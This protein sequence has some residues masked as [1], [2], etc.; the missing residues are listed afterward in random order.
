[1][2]N[3]VIAVALLLALV[4][5]CFRIVYYSLHGFAYDFAI[6]ATAALALRRGLPLYD[7]L[8]MRQLGG[9]YAGPKLQGLF[10]QPF[11][12]Y[13]GPPTTAL[14]LV[15][16]TLLTYPTAIAVYR[17]CCLIVFVAALW[18]A[19]RSVPRE[20]RTRGM[21][22]ALF[23]L[24]LW[25]G[26]YISI[27][28]G[29]VDAFI[30]LSFALSMVVAGRERPWFVGISTGI[31]ALLK[32]SP[33]ILIPVFVLRRFYREVVV[34]LLTIGVLLALAT[35]VAGTHQMYIFVADI[36]PAL[37]QG[38]LHVENQSLPA[39][40]ARLIT[41]E[42]NFTDYTKGLGGFRFLS[43]PIALGGIWLAWLVARRRAD[44]PLFVSILLLA[45]LLAGPLTWGHYASWACI[46]IIPMLDQ[47]LWER[48]SPRERR[49]L[50]TALLVGF[51]LIGVPI[52]A[53]NPPR[54]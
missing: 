49:Y 54:K 35:W 12:S 46:A 40:I 17:L 48:R 9:E 53:I 41:P 4:W 8:L 51:L 27:T 20:S 25:D 30:A 28:I 32:V 38:S 11:N 36:A 15:P 7:P 22:W 5:F 42:T 13:I 10:T 14:L 26:V 1:M 50:G 23:A 37:S 45:A 47:G 6:N 21:L 52:Y 34:A 18:I 39:Y 33:S 2:K 24:F 31:A 44:H 3:R 43:I 29:Q 16:F 19:S